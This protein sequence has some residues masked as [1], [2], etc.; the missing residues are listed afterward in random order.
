MV[1]LDTN[2]ILRYLLQDVPKQ[3]AKIEPLFNEIAEGKAQAVI[4]EAVLAECVYV[5]DAVYSVPKAEI[6]KSLRDLLA[7]KGFSRHLHHLLRDAL[8]VF[9]AANIS[10]VD[11]IVVIMAKHSQSDLASFDRSLLKQANRGGVQAAL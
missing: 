3:V 7:Y 1:V 6:V 5:L 11:A 10:I 4:S 8:D 9:A 2:V